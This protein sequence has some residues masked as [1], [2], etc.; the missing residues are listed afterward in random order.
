MKNII[1]LILIFL[2][3]NTLMAD[4]KLR[5]PYS[6][7]YYNHYNQKGIYFSYLSN[8]YN[9]QQ[10]KVYI[11]NIN[12]CYYKKYEFNDTYSQIV[13]Y[14]N[15]PHMNINIDNF[16]TPFE[17]VQQINIGPKYN[18]FGPP[19]DGPIETILP[20]FIFSLIYLLVY[21]KLKR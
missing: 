15:H 10:S 14:N 13:Y 5:N 8:D 20:L 7:N 18:A 3:S 4:I 9:I 19:M 2:I 21:F 17:D 16:N 11:N 1:S 12:E 6:N